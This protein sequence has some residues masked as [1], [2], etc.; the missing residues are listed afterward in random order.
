LPAFVG[1]YGKFILMST[2]DFDKAH[3][4]TIKHQNA[5]SFFSRLMPGIRTIISLPCGIVRV[6]F[7]RFCIYTFTGAL[8][9]CTLL[10]YIGFKLGQHSQQVEHF[11]VLFKVAIVLVVIGL[12]AF[13][14]WNKTRK[15][16]NPS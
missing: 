1:K 4:W 11:F 2:A 7:I 3:K 16:S 15:K 8:I 10:T 13:Y 5:V 6:N 14:I 9:W 12:V